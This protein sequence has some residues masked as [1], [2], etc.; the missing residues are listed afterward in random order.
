MWVSSQPFV[1]VGDR[2]VCPDQATAASGE[3]HEDCHWRGYLFLEI[4]ES[5]GL[6][7]SSRLRHWACSLQPARSRHAESIGRAGIFLSGIPYTLAWRFRQGQSALFSDLHFNWL[8]ARLCLCERILVRWPRFRAGNLAPSPA[9]SRRYARTV[10]TVDRMMTE[11]PSRN[12]GW[13]KHFAK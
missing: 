2:H 13:E 7:T 4:L 6:C 12:R 3:G 11:R 8:S 1:C 10:A 9:N 5:R